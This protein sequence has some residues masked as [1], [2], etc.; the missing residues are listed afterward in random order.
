MKIGLQLLCWHLCY[1][2]VHIIMG[3]FIMRAYGI[4][5]CL[6]VRTCYEFE[7]VG[8]AAIGR[9]VLPRLI[10]NVECVVLFLIRRI[11]I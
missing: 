7:L 10:V 1:Y 11:C 6:D 4:L 5:R 8:N 2:L 9:S 3:A